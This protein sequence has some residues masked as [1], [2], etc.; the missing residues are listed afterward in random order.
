MRGLEAPDLSDSMVKVAFKS[1]KK[2]EALKEAPRAVM[3][4]KLLTKARNKLK[5]L[6]KRV[7]WTILTFLFL[8]S[9]RGSEI[10]ATDSKWY[11]PMKTMCGDDLKLVPVKALGED[12]ETIQIASSSQRLKDLSQLR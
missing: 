6:R 8:G 4:L 5:S 10:L 3:T 12:V 2:K 1:L 11:D 7:I 9:F